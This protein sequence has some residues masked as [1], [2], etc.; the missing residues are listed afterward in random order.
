MD[1]ASQTALSA[2]SAQLGARLLPT[3]RLDVP[4]SGLLCFA[5]TAAFQSHFNA[6]LRERKV[7][8]EYTALVMPGSAML[9]PR[10]LVHWMERDGRAP[11]RLYAEPCG[12]AQRCES[13]LLSARRVR[14]RAHGSGGGVALLEVRLKLETGRTHQLRAQLA[15]EG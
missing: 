14:A 6:A 2:L 13:V 9:E 10:R 4:T 7:E 5:R 11:K 12:D 3:S 8:K 15:F 1:N